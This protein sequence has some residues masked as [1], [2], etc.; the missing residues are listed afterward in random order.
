MKPNRI[1]SALQTM[2]ALIESG[3]E[4]PDAH[5]RAGEKHSLVGRQY[6]LLTEAYDAWCVSLDINEN[7]ALNP[8]YG[9]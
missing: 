5:C 1:E 3:M 7:P 6:T 4:Y 8:E 2:I 9:R